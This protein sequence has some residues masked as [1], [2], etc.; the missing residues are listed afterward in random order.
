M[1][2]QYLNDMITSKGAFLQCM[3]G[4]Q[5]LMTPANG[6]QFT[7]EELQ[8]FVGGYIEIV[9]LDDNTLMVVNEEGK[10]H[11]LGLNIMATAIYQKLTRRI[12][13]IVGN[14]LICPRHMID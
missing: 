1:T 9:F 7:L 3:N 2:P 8:G 14:A 5:V 4:A 6:K 12:D 13:T 11:G 10:L